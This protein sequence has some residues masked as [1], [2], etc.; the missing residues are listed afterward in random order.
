[1][2]TLIRRL[3]GKIKGVI[4]GFDRIVFKGGIRP[5]LYVGGASA[6]LRKRG[7]LNRD[8]KPWMIEQSRSIVQAAERLSRARCGVG[9]EHIGSCHTDK[10]A[11]VRQRQRRSGIREGLLGVWSCLE[12]CQS[13]RARFDARAGFPQLQPE[14]T[15]CRHLYFYFDHALYGLMSVRLQTWFPYSLQIALNGRQWLRRSLE[16]AGARFVVAGNKFLELDDVAQA[17][18]HLDAQCRARWARV[19]DGFVPEVFPDFPRIL[20]SGLGYYWTLWQSEWARDYLFADPDAIEPLHEAFVRHALISGTGE[21]VM[22]YLG[23]P[24]DARGQ[25][26]RFSDPAVQTRLERWR[27]GVRIRHWVDG[28]SVKLYNEHTVLRVETTLNQPGKFRVHRRPQGAGAGTPKRRMPL[29]KGVA[30]V[31]LRAQVSAEVNQRFVEQMAT[32]RDDTPIRKLLVGV[33][34]A[35][36]V[37]GRRIRALD[38]TGKDRELLEALSDPAHAVR[39]LSNR[40]LQ[41]ALEGKAWAKGRSGRRLSSRI[42]RHLR[43]LRDHG[44]IRKV[45]ARRL[46]TLT[47]AGRKLTTALSAMLSASTQRLIENAA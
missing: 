29:R 30:D 11:L 33:T 45:P 10:E 35:R 24:L 38:L 41:K 37:G 7:V 26:H 2:D 12:S 36:R 47:D 19:L 22:R 17:Q 8:F 25:P 18:R 9:V 1:M 46:Y 39:G 5:L 32:V 40:S 20:G 43:L 44:L 31:P 27:E 28:N 13:Y 42:T 4:E 3:G 34:H 15:R 16:R 21:R 6:F 14:R 23:R